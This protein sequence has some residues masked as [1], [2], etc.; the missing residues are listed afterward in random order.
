VGWLSLPLLGVGTGLVF[1]DRSSLF[2]P[3]ALAGACGWGALLVFEAAAGEAVRLADAAG[4]VLGVP[5]VAFM[6]LTIAFA[7]FVAG[8]AALTTQYL[9]WLIQRLRLRRNED[10]VRTR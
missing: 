3:T 4:A 7:A 10:P 1:A 2:V 6:L 5:G 8:G 9:A